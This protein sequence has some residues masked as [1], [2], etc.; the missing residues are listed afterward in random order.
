MLKKNLIFFILL[1]LLSLT[2]VTE[3]A[4]R[5]WEKFQVIQ[6]TP[7][8]SAKTAVLIIHPPGD[9][10]TELD[11]NSR[12]YVGKRTWEKYMNSHPKVDCYFIKCV[13]PDQMPF[14]GKKVLQRGNYLYVS[15]PNYIYG[16]DDILYKTVQS[17]DFLASRGYTHYFRTNLNVFLDLK[18]LNEYLESHASSM[19]TT[20]M[21]E[22]W[23]PVGYSI[24]YSSDVAT[25]IVSEYKRISGNREI[26]NRLHPSNCPDDAGL[27]MLALGV[28]YGHSSSEHPFKCCSSLTSGVSQRM[29]AASVNPGRYTKYGMLL[30]P[31]LSY[32]KIKY[33]IMNKNNTVMIYRLKADLNLEENKEVYNLLL[34]MHYPELI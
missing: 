24:L 25:H 33:R 13:K 1:F 17:M 23:Y 4:W 7:R 3:G 11:E 18:K 28:W 31:P 2:S 21:N 10:N 27:C 8:K 29:C 15:D 34:K 22:M 19:Y 16:L 32:K 14:N 20:F 9:E 12:W 6:E 30:I 5:G 26:K